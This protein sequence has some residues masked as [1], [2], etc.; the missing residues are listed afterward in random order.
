MQ[1]D[2]IFSNKRVCARRSAFEGL[3]EKDTMISRSRPKVEKFMAPNRLNC[4]VY[5]NS[6]GNGEKSAF[7]T[8]RRKD[9]AIKQKS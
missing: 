3:K 7:Y 2:L 9:V 5:E 4:G 6:K 1:S 8:A